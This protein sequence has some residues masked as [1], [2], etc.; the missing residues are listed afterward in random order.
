MNNKVLTDPGEVRGCSTKT[1]VI[2]SL[3]DSVTLTL[4]SI[5]ASG[6]RVMAFNYKIDYVE[7]FKSASLVKKIMAILPTGQ[8][9]AYW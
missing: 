2:I 1:V 4:R 3:R 9:L 5:I 7:G 6:V 8:N